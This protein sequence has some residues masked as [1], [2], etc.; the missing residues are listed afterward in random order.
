MRST[1]NEPIVPYL[2][3]GKMKL[4][5]RCRNITLTSERE[6]LFYDIQ[7][8]IEESKDV[9]AALNIYLSPSVLD[10]VNR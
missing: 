2:F 7:L 5:V 9:Y 6:E 1:T 10:G 8:N 4:C 3:E